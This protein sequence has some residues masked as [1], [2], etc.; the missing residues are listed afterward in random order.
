MNG[1][2]YV[3]VV[4]AFQGGPSVA[5]QEFGSKAACENAAK[6]V[7]EFFVELPRANPQAVG[8]Q[9]VPKGEKAGEP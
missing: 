8:L 4:V 9:C 5:F 7:R 3:L 2:V 1:L 6:T